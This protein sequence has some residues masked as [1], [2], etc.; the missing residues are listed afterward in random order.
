VDALGQAADL[1][2][3]QIT[4]QTARRGAK[5]PCAGRPAWVSANPAKI[6]LYLGEPRVKR[7]FI[8]RERAD[9]ALLGEL[10]DIMGSEVTHQIVAYKLRSN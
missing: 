4:S 1:Y 8:G 3:G 5:I 9:K 6:Q 2:L 7:H 10:P